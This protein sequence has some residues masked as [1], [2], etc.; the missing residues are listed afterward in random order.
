MALKQ[1][2]RRHSLLTA[3]AADENLPVNADGAMF[4][5]GAALAIAHPRWHCECVASNSV[6]CLDLRQPLDLARLG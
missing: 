5:G 2:D 3:A 6:A 1:G 4:P